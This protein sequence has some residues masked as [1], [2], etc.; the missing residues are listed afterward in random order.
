MPF[1]ARIVIASEDGSEEQDEGIK[2]VKELM[3]ILM[4]RACAEW[5]RVSIEFLG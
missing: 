2:G 1:A 3:W 5:R 4:F